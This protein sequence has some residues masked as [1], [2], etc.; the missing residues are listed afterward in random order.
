M[1][2]FELVDFELVDILLSWT[3]ELCNL[4][5]RQSFHYFKFSCKTNWFDQKHVLC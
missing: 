5:I 1:F 4:N 3:T 2:A